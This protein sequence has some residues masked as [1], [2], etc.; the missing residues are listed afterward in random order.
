MKLSENDIQT[1]DRY[2]KDKGIG[3]WDIRLEMTDH[4]A[5]EMESKNGSY[6]FHTLFMHVLDRLGWKNDLK[7]FEQRRLRSI[8]KTVR[9]KYVSNF[10]GLFTNIKTLIVVGF[11]V[12]AYYLLFQNFSSKVFSIISLMLF[13]LPIL[14]FTI[15]Y[16]YMSIKFKKSGY[17]LYGYFYIIFSMLMSNLLYQLPRPDGVFEVTENV[18]QSIIFF[19]TIFNVLFI[20]SGIKIYLETTKKYRNLQDKL[21]V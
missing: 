15:H 4:I 20:Y 16:A 11:F 2:L 14:Y 13:G 3:Y 19:T 21:A 12:F 5:C 17:L 6:D 1:I 8:N 9:K 7:S 10:V 18:R